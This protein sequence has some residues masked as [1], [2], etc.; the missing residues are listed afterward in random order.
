MEDNLYNAIE[1][2]NKEK[3]DLKNSK[4][5]KIGNAITNNLDL[6]TK[7]KFKKIMNNIKNKYLKRV[8]NK[9][10]YH[11]QTIIDEKYN[12]IKYK[13]KKIA[14]YTCIIG[15]YDDIQIP[16]IEFDNV[17]YFILSDD[18]EKYKDYR[19]YFKLVQIKK[20][21]LERGDIVANRYVKLHPIDFFKDYDYSIY[22]DGN[23]RIISDVRTFINKCSDGTGIAMHT[24]R[25]RN[26]IYEE[27]KV[28]KLLKRGNS[29]KIDEQ[30]Q[31]YSKEGFPSDFGMNE[32]TI[33]VSD[34]NNA[35][36]IRLLDEWYREFVK[37]ESLRDQLSWP[38][39]LW[40]NNYMISDIGSLGNNI[41]QNYK[42]EMVKHK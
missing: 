10:Y 40:K 4:E 8:I 41:Y 27:A 7:F 32:A 9:K 15:N 22:I 12:N 29:K 25:E 21:I 37:T 33:I 11:P 3:I 26:D 14:I 20:E 28:C 1:K 36:S 16:L 39:V 24:H 18:I 6:V 42:V 34:L 38:Y 23:V 17:D 19:K 31:R 30:M 2:M 5:Y 35:E 13:E